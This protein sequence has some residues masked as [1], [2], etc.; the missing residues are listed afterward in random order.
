MSGCSCVWIR[1]G[2]TPA[3]LV[4]QLVGAEYEMD[5]NTKPKRKP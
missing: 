1:L 4:L 5:D 2:F 3:H